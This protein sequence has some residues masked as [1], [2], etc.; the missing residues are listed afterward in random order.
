MVS[1][2]LH[3]KDVV[4]FLS[5]TLAKKK[6]KTKNHYV[7]FNNIKFLNKFIQTMKINNVYM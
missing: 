3:T 4:S 1:V 5:C 7:K 6:T 2:L